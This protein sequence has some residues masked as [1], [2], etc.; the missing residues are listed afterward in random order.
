M[1]YQ[2][3]DLNDKR[4]DLSCATIFIV[5]YLLLK[6]SCG[7]CCRR[8]DYIPEILCLDKGELP[9]FCLWVTA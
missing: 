5:K 7:C 9:T 6:L 2:T 8:Y 4:N 1:I 3:K